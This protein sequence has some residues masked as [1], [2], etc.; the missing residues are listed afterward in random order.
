MTEFESRISWNLSPPRVRVEHAALDIAGCCPRRAD[1][2]ALLTDLCQRRRT[3][4]TRLAA[5]LASRRRQPRG[6]WLSEVLADA[7]DGALSVLEQAYLNLER[8][9]KPG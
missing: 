6:A 2:I 3:T 1:A 7:G 9:H 4:P 8:A 5:T